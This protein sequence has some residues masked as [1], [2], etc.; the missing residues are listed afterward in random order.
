M[1]SGLPK[2]DTLDSAEMVVSFDGEKALSD[3]PTLYAEEHVEE[4]TNLALAMKDK[5]FE[6]YLVDLEEEHLR[7]PAVYAIIPGILFRERTRIP[8]LYQ[9]VR[10]LPIYLSP[11]ENKTLLEEILKEVEDR[12]Y[13][14]AYYGNALKGIERLDEAIMAYEKALSL[15]PSEPIRLPF[16]AIWQMPILERESGIRW[17][18][19]AKKPFLLVKPQSYITFLVGP[20]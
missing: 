8:Y 9:M 1:E 11:Q 14:W 15:S 6:V 16:T 5:G 4:M 17:L 2:F 12:Y 10:T 18:R 3:L 20:L 19:S 13:I 7:L